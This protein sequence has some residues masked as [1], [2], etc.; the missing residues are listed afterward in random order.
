MAKPISISIIKI[1]E[2]EYILKTEEVKKINPEK[3]QIG[4]Q[5]DFDWELEAERLMLYTTVFYKYSANKAAFDLSKFTLLMG[6]EVK[7]LNQ[8]LKLSDDGFEIDDVYL[9]TFVGA[10]ISSARGMLAYKHSGTV[11]EHFYLPLVDPKNFIENINRQVPSTAP[12]KIIPQKKSL[13]KTTIKST[14]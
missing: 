6:F 10:A 11:L 2:E 5:F 3:L 8:I 14:S 12:K 13:G 4:F 9:L 1:E 7:E